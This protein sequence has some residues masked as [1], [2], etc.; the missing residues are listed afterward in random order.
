[1]PIKYSTTDGREPNGDNSDPARYLVLV[2]TKAL[3]RS[4]NPNVNRYLKK[5]LQV[6]KDLQDK[7]FTAEAEV[8][9]GCLQDVSLFWPNDVRVKNFTYTVDDQD[10]EDEDEDDDG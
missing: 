3:Q 10:N 1:M 4:A 6:A 5:A 9:D 8:S 2:L 7:K